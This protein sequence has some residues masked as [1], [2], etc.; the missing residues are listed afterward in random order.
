MLD[1]K[2]IT[3]Q[4]L[5][6]FAQFLEQ[7]NYFEE[8]FKVFESGLA[9]FKWPGLYDIWLVYINK[10]VKRYQ[11]DKLE[12]ARDLFEKVLQSVPQKVTLLAG[13]SRSAAPLALKLWLQS[14]SLKPQSPVLI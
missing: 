14:S 10:F 5:L 4:M 11:R 7:N 2:V 12:R 6:N 1:L 3:P 13:F 8:S 9:M